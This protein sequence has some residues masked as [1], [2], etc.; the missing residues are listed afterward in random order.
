MP[1]QAPSTPTRRGSRDAPAPNPRSPSVFLAR[2]AGPESVRLRPVSLPAGFPSG[3]QPALFIHAEDDELI[4]PW[5]SRALHGAYVGD[6][7]IIIVGDGQSHNSLR[8]RY[9]VDSACS[10]LNNCLKGG[11]KDAEELF[12]GVH[13][14]PPGRAPR[15]LT[16]AERLALQKH[17]QS[18]D[19]G[20]GDDDGSGADSEARG[21]LAVAPP[22][23]SRLSALPACASLLV[24]PL[25]T[26]E[27]T[28]ALRS[29]PQRTARLS[30]PCAL[31]SR[32]G[33]LASSLTDAPRFSSL[34]LRVLRPPQ[35]AG[36]GPSQPQPPPPKF[37]EEH[38]AAAASSSA[39][40]AAA[41][42][43]SRGIE[44]DAAEWLREALESDGPGP[45]GDDAGGDGGE[46]QWEVGSD[47]YENLDGARTRRAGGSPALRPRPALQA[48][49]GFIL[50]VRTEC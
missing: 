47:D 41:G 44:D 28:H 18:L 5:H 14:E 36:A 12:K 21:A 9:V 8:P 2:V 17:M 3:L 35:D 23:P 11:L 50:V 38:R 26:Y 13:L 27:W 6:K 37:L 10:F 19:G 16:L 7:R 15:Q 31:A 1:S 4:Q 33:S 24:M 48:A 45:G 42:G 43:S 49:A 40:A 25:S 32:C 22:P 46:G 29:A 39:A 20:G 30:R 34:R